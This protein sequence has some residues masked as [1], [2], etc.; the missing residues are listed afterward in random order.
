[1]RL[2]D[3]KLCTLP[4]SGSFYSQTYWTLLRHLR[5]INA[6]YSRRMV[7]IIEKAR[8]HHATLHPVWRLA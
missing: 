6:R 4:P 1:M 8:Y 2:R 7:I 3:V 5:R